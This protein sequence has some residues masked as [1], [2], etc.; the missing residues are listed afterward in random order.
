MKVPLCVVAAIIGG[1]VVASA[2]EK[3][4]GTGSLSMW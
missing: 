3:V 1:V 4:A 2:A